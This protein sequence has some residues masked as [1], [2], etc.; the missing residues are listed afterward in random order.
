MS[1]FMCYVINN[2]YE[3]KF[4]MNKIIIMYSYTVIR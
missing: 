4:Y 3:T 1:K 2:I